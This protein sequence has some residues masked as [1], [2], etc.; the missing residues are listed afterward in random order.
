VLVITKC[1][2]F[3]PKNILDAA[4]A[5]LMRKTHIPRKNA[6]THLAAQG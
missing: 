5:A 1:D 2:R 4:G 3:T 6:Q